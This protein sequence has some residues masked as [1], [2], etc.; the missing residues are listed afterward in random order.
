[1][2]IEQIKLAIIRSDLN[3][4]QLQEISDALR[5]A[6]AQLAQKVKR[7]LTIG[8]VV[9]F[10]HP[11]HGKLRGTVIK[12]NIKNV[13]VNVTSTATGATTRAAGRW[14]VGATLLTQVDA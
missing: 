9:E 7:G 10:D 1:M 2:D 6:R 8:D 5:F 12:I 11:T 4:A 13:K 3:A 14:N